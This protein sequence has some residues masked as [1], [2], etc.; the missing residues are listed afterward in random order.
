MY[1]KIQNDIWNVKKEFASK[2]KKTKKAKKDDRS[3]C[4][5]NDEIIPEMSK[6]ILHL[7]WNN[8]KMLKRMIG[9]TV[10]TMT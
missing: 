6:L 4:I 5:K 9:Q 2:L 3:K 1:P 10:S 8:E 7:K